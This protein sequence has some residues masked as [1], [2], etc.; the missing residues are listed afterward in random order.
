[1]FELTGSVLIITVRN[2]VYHRQTVC[3]P[4]KD[5]PLR[6]WIYFRPLSSGVTLKH[7][8]SGKSDR[9]KLDHRET[10]TFWTSKLNGGESVMD[11]TRRTGFAFQKRRIRARHRFSN[12]TRARPPIRLNVCRLNT[13]YRNPRGSNCFGKVCLGNP[14]FLCLFNIENFIR[15]SNGTQRCRGETLHGHFWKLGTSLVCR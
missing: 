14:M 8:Y 5:I 1:M 4:N 7:D 13:E 15:K 3:F 11:N 12:G 2:S 10:S 9:A 6:V